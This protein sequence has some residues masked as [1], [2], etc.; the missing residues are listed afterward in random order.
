M[1]LPLL[2]S[3]FYHTYEVQKGLII[4]LRDDEKPPA[5]QSDRKNELML[6]LQL[7]SRLYLVFRVV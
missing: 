2:K 4:I 7:G 1:G 6:G 5:T 3:A